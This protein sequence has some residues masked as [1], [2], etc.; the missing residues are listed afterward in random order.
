MRTVLN[1]MLVSAIGV[2]MQVLVGAAQQP[3][4][5]QRNK[6]LI[7]DFFNFRGA[8]QERAMKFMSDTYR[9]HNPR[10]LK[11][12]TYTGKHGWEAWVAANEQAQ[13]LGNLQLVAL[14]G[15]PLR[16]P[17]ILI[18]E[19]DFALAV[20][21]GNLPDPGDPMQRYEAFAFE[22]F[23][24]ANGKFIEHWDQVRLTPGWMTPRPPEQPLLQAEPAGQAPAAPAARPAPPASEPPAGCVSNPQ[25]VAQNKQIVSVVQRARRKGLTREML[26]AECDYAAIVWKQVLPDPDTAGRTWEAFTFD[27]YQI[28]DGKIVAH[29]DESTP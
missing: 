13:K 1:R 26:I 16:D 24:F 10:F 5:V 20:Y 3:S 21:R 18:G 7:N 12:D 27:A 23:R 15:I 28:R 9:Q 25:T 8:R 2:A 4:D 11:M 22:A 17:I 19:G 6:Q 29:W 14:G